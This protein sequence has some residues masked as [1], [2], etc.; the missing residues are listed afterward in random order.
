MSRRKFYPN[1]RDPK[2]AW[3]ATYAGKIGSIAAKYG[4]GAA[5]LAE[6]AADNAWIQFWTQFRNDADAQKQALTRYFNDICGDDSTLPPPAAVNW[7]LT[8]GAPPEVPPGIEYR[9][10]QVADQV[11][12][13]MDYAKAD[14][15]LV[16]FEL[17]EGVGSIP[18][19]P[20]DPVSPNFELRTLAGFE[21]EAKFKR[22]GNSA[23]KFQY[24]YIGGTW[25]TAAVLLNSPGSFAVPPAVPG[26]AQQIEIRAIY[27]LGNEEVGIYSDAKTAFL[28]P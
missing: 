17:P 1:G 7:S 3:H 12:G 11:M 14:G 21:L 24:R 18:L 19:A 25:A 16:G 4:I 8:A 10:Y 13:H 27:L 2:A 22:N 28:A 26:V 6:I 9:V 5:T 15:E 23:V 20:G